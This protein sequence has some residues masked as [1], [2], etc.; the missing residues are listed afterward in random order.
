MLYK[1]VVIVSA[2]M[3]LKSLHGCPGCIG[4]LATDSPPFFSK[5]FYRPYEKHTQHQTAPLKLQEPATA[6]ALQSAAAQPQ[7]DNH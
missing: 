4:H 7:N 5:D 3:I 6:L 2:L 1:I